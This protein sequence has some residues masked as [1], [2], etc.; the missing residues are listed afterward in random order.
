MNRCAQRWYFDALARNEVELV[1]FDTDAMLEALADQGFLR[2]APP[3][4]TNLLPEL[5]IIR[6][7]MKEDK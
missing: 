2:L 5:A 6:K 7:I 4:V 1:P 3:P